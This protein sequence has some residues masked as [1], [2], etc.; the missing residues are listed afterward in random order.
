MLYDII[1]YTLGFFV[2]LIIL[3]PLAQIALVI[4]TGLLSLAAIIIDPTAEA[5]TR[6][7]RP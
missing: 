3:T 7:R 1:S 6:L 5:I 2:I 4:L